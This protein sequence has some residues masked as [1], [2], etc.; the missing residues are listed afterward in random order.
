M[1]LGR[2]SVAAELEGS[3]VIN[4]LL[5][6]A[7]NVVLLAHEIAEKIHELMLKPL[8]DDSKVDTGLTLGQIGPDSLMAIELRG[9]LR[10]VFCIVMSVL[11]VMG[12]GSLLH[13]GGLVASTLGEKLSRG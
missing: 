12:S 6:D 13:L 2:V 8:D 5:D 9:W 10:Q 4:N 3:A 11:E 7:E 1:F